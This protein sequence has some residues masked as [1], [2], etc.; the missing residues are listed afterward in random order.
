MARLARRSVAKQRLVR[1]VQYWLKKNAYL[2]QFQ[3]R[4]HSTPYMDSYGRP[5]SICEGG[6]VTSWGG[7]A[8]VDSWTEYSIKTIEQ[9]FRG[10]QDAAKGE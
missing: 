3:F 7:G 5:V 1:R 6:V 10:A 2:S 9:L 8:V 4:L